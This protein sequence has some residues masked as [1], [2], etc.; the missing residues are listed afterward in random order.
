M[1]NDSRDSTRKKEALMS[2]NS[3]VNA[4]DTMGTQAMAE[5]NQQNLA[6]GV[7]QSG[8]IDPNMTFSSFGDLQAKAPQIAKALMQSF[9]YTIIMDNKYAMDQYIQRLKEAR[10]E[11]EHTK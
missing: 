2:L 8:S 4:V 6:N 1:Y 3:S 7:S 11:E 5:A 10:Q 9:A